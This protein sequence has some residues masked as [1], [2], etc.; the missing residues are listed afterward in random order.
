MQNN[1]LIRGVIP[2]CLACAIILTGCQPTSTPQ[3][4][5]LT[6]APTAAPTNAT[7]AYRDPSLPIEKR[8]KDLLARMTLEEKI[9]QMTQVANT[10]I[11][12][13]DITTR[14]ISSILSGGDGA[15]SPNSLVAWANM[16]NGD[17]PYALKTRLGI[18]LI[19][20][21]D[22]VH[23]FGGLQ[24]A[25]VFPHNIGLGATRD[26]DLAQRIGRATAEEIAATGITWNFSPVIAVPQDIRWGR[27]YEGYSE[28]T[29]LVSQLSA[30]YI[31]GLQEKSPAGSEPAGGSLA[32]LATAKHFIGDGGTTWGTS[33]ADGY[34]IDQGDM[35]VDEAT[36][37]ALFLPPYKAAIDAGAKSIMVSFNSWNGL[38]MHAQKKLLTD[39]LKGELG[40]KGFLVSDWAGI[41]QISNNYDEA[42]VTSINAG[43]DMIMV[44]DKYLAFI[45]GLTRAVKSGRVPMSRIDDA[46]RRILTIKMELGLFERPL[47]DPATLSNVGSDA[48][49]QLAREAVRKSLVLLK[50]E[51]QALPISK[52]TS[53]IFVAGEADNVGVQ[54]GGWTL[55]WQGKTGNDMPGTTILDGIKQTVSSKARVE[56]NRFGKF[57]ELKDAQGKPLVADVGIVVVGEA[58]Y[59]EGPGDRAD[60]SL[61]SDQINL[62]NRVKERSKK[63]AVILISG[64]PMIVTE[65][66]P[67]WDA[68]V[69]VWLP[70]TEGEGVADVLFGD[71][72]FTGK[73]PY[74]WPRWNQQLPFDFKH[75]PKEGC[76]AP[77]FPFGYGLA[78]SDPSPKQFNCPKP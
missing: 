28:N 47:S 66:W 30:A 10:Y 65:Q 69:A 59:A 5:A 58:P 23:G 60:L 62:L 8:V 40:F 20:G 32:V 3:P 46:V 39:L 27:T 2:I 55:V 78:A 13:D 73:L 24:G 31:R 16:V 26:P 9:G 25:T 6:V 50:N 36:L 76:D 14:F 41:N 18:P 75:L 12:P 44:P 19:Y 77:L 48:H 53:L 21:V 22:A 74:T 37:R 1:L 72:S 49:R 56:Y 68:F 43:L 71:A 64:R 54:C 33:R 51:N 15:P 17:Q 63:L 42:I 45:D 70:G 11:K 57:D 4:I 61:P 35:Q 67:N 38:K 34:K 29:E 52:N 7:P